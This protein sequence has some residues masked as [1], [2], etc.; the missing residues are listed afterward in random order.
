MLFKSQP[1]RRRPSKPST[2]QPTTIVAIQEKDTG[3]VRW[4]GKKKGGIA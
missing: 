1:V 3:V 2:G 4:I